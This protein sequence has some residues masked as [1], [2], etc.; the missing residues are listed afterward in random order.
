MRILPRMPPA[1]EGSGKETGKLVRR[2]VEVTTERE[3]VWILARDHP[4][5]DA[6]GT[7]CREGGLEKTCKELQPPSQP[8]AW[9]AEA[10]A[11]EG[12][13]T[14]PQD[15]TELGKSATQEKQGKID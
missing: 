12:R 3:S 15:F 11:L 13:G 7:T 5:D 10:P 6:E 4:T 14:S 8:S 2:R 9:H 1:T